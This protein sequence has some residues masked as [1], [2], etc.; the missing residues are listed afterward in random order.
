M[1]LSR[2]W[3][4]WPA[5]FFF[6]SFGYYLLVKITQESPLEESRAIEDLM[7][8]R[9][10]GLII[11]P[12]EQEMYNNDILR[13]SLNRFPLVLI[14]R[15]MKVIET[16]S[17]A[18]DNL[19]GAYRAV[20]HLLDRGHE[21]VA[22]ITVKVTNSVTADRAT[23]F[24]KAFLKR[25]LLIHKNLW[26]MIGIPDI[27]SGK[28]VSVIQ[29]FLKDNPNVTAVFACNAELAGYMLRAIQAINETE[30]RHLEL[31]SFDQSDLADV[32]YVKQNVEEMCKV[33]IDLLLEQIQGIYKPRRVAIPVTFFHKNILN[34]V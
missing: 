28:G 34:Q 2:F 31:V 20:H 26:C 24:E 3:P 21:Q 6:C 9:V 5:G 8:L 33:T 16:Y 18:A 25:N 1:Y 19:D 27:A 30:G 17:V 32:S 10:K 15:F 4:Q 13:L 7:L 23:G 14:D 22:Y 12:I 11:F 29:E